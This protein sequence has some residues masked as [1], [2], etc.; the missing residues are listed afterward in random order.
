MKVVKLSSTQRSQT[1][2]SI[3]GGII[4]LSA[5]MA[6]A[7]AAQAETHGYVQAFI[8]QRQPIQASADKQISAD[9]VHP[10]DALTKRI[11]RDNEQLDRMI[12]GICTGC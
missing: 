4:M 9:Q 12:R 7:D 6:V 11:E 3:F 1:M 5:S 8:G 10:K 2:R